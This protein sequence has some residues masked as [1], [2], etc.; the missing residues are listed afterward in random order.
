MTGRDDG[1]D[2]G[3]GDAIK[4]FVRIR[5]PD[6][7]DTDIGQ[8]LALK[9]LDETSLVMN[10]KPE[11]R[12]FTFDKVADVTSTQESLFN[13]IGKPIIECCVSGY[14]GTIFAYGQTGSGKTHTML[15]PCE[16][17]DNFQHEL[18]GIIPRSFENLFN[19]VAS[20]QE[21]NK[22]KEFL[23]K[24]SFLEIYRED[25]FDLLEPSNRGLHL[26]ENM[27]KGVFVE[28]LVENAVTSAVEA[29]QVLNSGW[30]NRRVASTSMN[31]ESS[32]S[33]AVF[34]ITIESKEKKDGVQSLR[35][36]QLNL[37]D[38]AGSERQKD[39]NAVGKR[40]KEAGSINKSLSVL[41]NVINSLVHISHGKTRHI[42]YRDSKLTFLLRDSL[43]GNAKT[44]IIACVHPSSKCFGESLSTLQFAGRAKMIKNKAVINEDSQGNVMALQ[45]EIRKLK[46]MLQQYTSGTIKMEPSMTGIQQESDNTSSVSDSEWKERFIQA[47]LLRENCAQEKM[48]FEEKLI[49]LRDQCNKKDACLQSTK[50]VVKFREN[51][52]SQLESALK[53]N[54][55]QS[56]DKD[57]YAEDLKAEISLLQEQVKQH[58]MV[59]K[60]SMEIQALKSQLKNERAQNDNT[61]RNKA[62]LLI[63]LDGKYKELTQ[64][65]K[66]FTPSQTPK[67]ENVAT[68]TVEKYKSQVNNLQEE[69][70]KLKQ[71]LTENAD[72][73]EKEKVELNSEIESLKSTVKDL[74]SSLKT[75]KLTNKIE[76]ENMNDI[77]LQTITQITTPKKAAYTLRNRVIVAPSTGSNTPS[78]NDSIPFEKD[79][80]IFDETQP[81]FMMEQAH[82]ALMDEMKILQDKN[83]SL[84]ERIAEFETEAIQLRQHISKVDHQNGQLNEI[85]DRE[86]ADL[87]S[88]AE[89]SE[90]QVIVLQKQLLE[91]QEEARMNKEE[92]RDYN[93]MMTSNEK[94]LDD[95]KKELKFTKEDNEKNLNTL[96]TKLVQLAAELD[97]I[98]KNLETTLETKESLQEEVDTLQV[99]KIFKDSLISEL[100][101]TL[102]NEKSKVSDLLRENQTLLQESQQE[103][104]TLSDQLRE[105]ERQNEAN[106]QTISNLQRELQNLEQTTNTQQKQLTQNTEVISDYLDKIKDLKTSLFEKN[107][108]LETEQEKTKSLEESIQSLVSEIKNVKSQ[109]LNLEE[110]K[111][112]MEEDHQIELSNV[113]EQVDC[114]TKNFNEL[115]EEHRKVQ[116][117][118]NDLEKQF[119]TLKDEKDAL[120]TLI[121]ENKEAY[122]NE[123]TDLKQQVVDAEKRLI[124]KESESEEVFGKLIEE[125][126]S[127]NE[128][129]KENNSDLCHSIKELQESKEEKDRENEELKNKLKV[130][131]SLSEGFRNQKQC[132]E[133]E[134]QNKRDTL[135]KLSVESMV[136]EEQLRGLESDFERMKEESSNIK[137]ENEVLQIRLCEVDKEMSEVNERNKILLEENAKL[138]GHQNLKQKIHYTA[139]LKDENN[140]LREQLSKHQQEIM[141]LK[142]GTPSK[143]ENR[144]PLKQ[145]NEKQWEEAEESL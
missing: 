58:P 5:P 124:D 10:S 17:A 72:A 63:E 96:E 86:R 81:D 62:D 48:I 95:L 116:K 102:R 139:K 91:S 117:S 38:L 105:E 25:V 127:K 71:Q 50:M 69:V 66:I 107:F 108:T 131:E 41:G 68:A 65:K 4:V 57:K 47:M 64:D 24:C 27:K 94:Q 53:K 6:S 18:R 8:V 79:E 109:M 142:S 126:T 88:R 143:K 40:L 133:Y 130:I 32:R 36:S 134:M 16:D 14:N 33:H 103:R 128:R 9:V 141:K 82:Q 61:N 70:A 43:G 55:L 46:E 59:A 112:T 110:E 11:P 26:R 54:G 136:K 135:D 138:V 87:A 77:H 35:M 19:N 85:L 39:S 3:E 78:L 21:M 101:E 100:E 73:A 29:Y 75:Q 7:Y 129:L 122:E 30:I 76:R 13:V 60:Y 145:W 121:K 15:G 51:R 137:A 98:T 89:S 104:S 28:G 118:K 123:V 114:L 97:N 2:S 56:D 20:E 49:K 140:F 125:L 90:K 44:H 23:L 120:N 52:I 106:N 12:I 31:R 45:I 119:E 99:E 113:N 22:G 67:E 80:D 37:V 92:A 115:E 83:N 42:P 132:L 1:K 74:S 111:K 84:S 34:T 93:V 144:S